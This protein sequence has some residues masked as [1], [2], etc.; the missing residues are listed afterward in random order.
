[1]NSSH[2]LDPKTRKSN[3]RLAVFLAFVAIAFYLA[4][5]VASQR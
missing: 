5:I 3:R 1:M 4:M 2:Q